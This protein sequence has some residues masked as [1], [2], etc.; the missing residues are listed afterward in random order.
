MKIFAFLV[1]FQN[2]RPAEEYDAEI[3]TIYNLNKEK[4]KLLKFCA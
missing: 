1:S 4:D 3:A 2:E